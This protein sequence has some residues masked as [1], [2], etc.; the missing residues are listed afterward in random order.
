MKPKKSGHK[1]E[2]TYARKH[3]NN[4]YKKF[5][6]MG[7]VC[8]EWSGIWTQHQ[9]RIPEISSAHAP[10]Y[11]SRKKSAINLDEKIIL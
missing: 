10:V 3:A 7:C 1:L 8:G 5:C 11:I 4:P 2:N 9:T 6:D